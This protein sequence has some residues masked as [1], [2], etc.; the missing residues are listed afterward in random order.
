MSRLS[1]LKQDDFDKLLAWL[2]DDREQAGQKYEE[3]R[4]SLIKIFSWRG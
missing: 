3:I 4:E 1:V 2:H